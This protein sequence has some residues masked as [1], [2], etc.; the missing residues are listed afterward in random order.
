[1]AYPISKVLVLS[2]LRSLDTNSYFHSSKSC[3]QGG[4]CPKY[5]RCVYFSA[6]GLNVGERTYSSLSS[7]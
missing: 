3:L 6:I 2:Q 4:L 5:L 7:S 1:M